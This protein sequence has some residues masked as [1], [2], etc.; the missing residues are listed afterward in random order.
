MP[1]KQLHGIRQFHSLSLNGGRGRSAT[2]GHCHPK[3]TRGRP[4]RRR[5]NGWPPA[6]LG[7]PGRESAALAADA[8]SAVFGFGRPRL[9]DRWVGEPGRTRTASTPHC[10]D[11]HARCRYASPVCG[12]D[13]A[14]RRRRSS[15]SRS[16][17]SRA[18]RVSLARTNWA[19][20]LA[21][22]ASWLVLLGR[23]V[24]H[25][26]LDGKGLCAGQGE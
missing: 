10:T 13:G 18:H 14:C 21:A 8:R 25:L 16:V 2:V 15:P 4:T 24:A 11:R 7:S 19:S 1:G 22:R 9:H 23:H 20:P 6:R 5:G 26:R 17:L 3:S 12:T